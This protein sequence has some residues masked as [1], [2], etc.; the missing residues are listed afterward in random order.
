[1]KIVMDRRIPGLRE[2]LEKRG[3]FDIVEKEGAEITPLDLRDAEVLFVRTR[4]R[5]DADLL[6][7][8]GI[9]LLG[10]A[11]I[12]TDHIDLPWCDKSS[13]RVVSAPGCNAP[14]VMQYVAS[15]LHEAGFDPSSQVLGIVGKGHIGSLVATL[16]RSA[17]TKVVVCDPLRKKAGMTDEEYLPMQEVFRQADAVTFHVPYTKEGPHPTHHMLSD[18]LLASLPVGH[19]KTIVNASRGLVVE[20][21]VL[22]SGHKFIIDTW[23]FEDNPAA[24]TAEERERVIRNAFIATPHIAGYSIQGKQR[25][26]DAMLRAFDVFAGISE[27]HGES[28]DKVVEIP[29]LTL[30][31]VIES[32]SPMEL[33]RDLKKNP[34]AFES[35][36]GAHLRPEAGFKD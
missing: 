33:S 1:M 25:A 11:T 26:T 6:R 34:E 8:S 4:T 28:E 16:Y 9:R 29:S 7:G 5:C 12:G 17:G 27:I 36:R 31:E 2:G 20:P 3:E 32:F 35:L 22:D 23:P 24:W 13:I 19:S 14:A 30:E 21:A 10:T 15:S 18:S